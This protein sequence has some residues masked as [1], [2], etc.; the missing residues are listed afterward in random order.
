LIRVGVM[1]ALLATPAAAQVVSPLTS[2][3]AVDTSDLATKSE[4][5]IAA[6]AAAQ[7][8]ASADAAAA[9]AAAACQ[10]SATVPPVEMIGGSAGSGDACRLANAAQP[11]ITRAGVVA[12]DTAGNWSIAWSAP[13]SAIPTVLPVPVNT[14]TQ[15][16]VCN[17]ATRTTTTATGRCWLARTLPAALVT[18]T[19]LIAY[20]VFG[21]PASG[22]SVQVIALPPTQ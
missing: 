22:V 1:L 6:Q 15:P 10:P 4:V 5:S 13:L 7:A 8:K 12:T 16:I 21:A 19:S 18:L 3:A 17:V 14:T 20:D 11:R 9:K 2:N